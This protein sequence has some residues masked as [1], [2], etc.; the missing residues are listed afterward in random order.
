MWNKTISKTACSEWVLRNSLYWMTAYTRWRLEDDDV[1]W[2]VSFD[3]FS[4]EI[5]FEF[6]RLRNDFQLRESLD[7][8]TGRVRAAII[9]NVLKSIDER[10][11]G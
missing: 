10:L 8:H 1:N 4:E 3:T 7:N 9:S 2:H 6:E 5:Q 11:A